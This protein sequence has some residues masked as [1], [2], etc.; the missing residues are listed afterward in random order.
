MQTLKLFMIYI[1]TLPFSSG[2]EIKEI[3]KPYKCKYCDKSYAKNQ[4]LML[5]TRIHTGENLFFCH[6]CSKKFLTKGHLIDHLNS[7]AK[8]KPTVCRLCHK[9]FKNKLEFNAHNE[10]CILRFKI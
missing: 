7:H 9:T 10:A 1:E 5:H 4:S 8:Q 3:K 2:V 6:L